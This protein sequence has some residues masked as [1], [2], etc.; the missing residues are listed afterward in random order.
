MITIVAIGPR[1]AAFYGCTATEWSAYAR[2][3]A[4]NEDSAQCLAQGVLASNFC[5]ADAAGMLAA[6][7][8]SAMYDTVNLD[9]DKLLGLEKIALAVGG[10]AGLNR[11]NA[12]S[13]MGCD[14]IDSDDGVD[15]ITCAMSAD[16]ARFG[17]LTTTGM[18]EIPVALA[19]TAMGADEGEPGGALS[20]LADSFLKR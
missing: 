18:A 4:G 14:D 2:E 3:L 7:V 8:M 5:E 9:D 12:A 16:I 17:Y 15:A 10:R 20:A 6:M 1:R 19:V 11:A 13:L